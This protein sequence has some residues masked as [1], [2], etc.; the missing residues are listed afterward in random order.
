[1]EVDGES[2][3]ARAVA[4]PALTG[5]VREGDR[6]LLNTTA[7][8]LGLGTVA[9]QLVA[10]IV[11]TSLLRRA[12]GH[13]GWRAIH[14][15]AYASWPVAVVHGLGTGS[16][17]TAGWMIAIDLL[18]GGAVLAALAGRLLAPRTDPLA[19]HRAGFRATVHRETLR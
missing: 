2:G 16:D 5:S 15:L 4:Y 1:M 18:C 3:T 6:V 17:A 9:A 8:W 19:G 12:I 7:V 11:V 13:R 10:A 14:W